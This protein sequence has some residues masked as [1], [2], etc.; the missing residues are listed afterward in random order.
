[1]DYEERINKGLKLYDSDY[2][3]YHHWYEAYKF[4]LDY[5]FDRLLK[6]DDDITFIDTN[7]FYEFIDYIISFQKI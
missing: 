2:K 3:S 1:M 5:D 7:R 6:I 4:Y